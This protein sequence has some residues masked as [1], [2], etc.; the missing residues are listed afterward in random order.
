MD[1]CLVFYKKLWIFPGILK[2]SC[3]WLANRVAKCPKSFCLLSG[4]EGAAADEAESTTTRS[5][6][7]RRASKPKHVLCFAAGSSMHLVLSCGFALSRLRFPRLLGVL[8][9]CYAACD[10]IIIIL[11]ESVSLC[12]SMCACECCR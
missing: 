1:F 9:V 10:I 4:A 6:R 7:P 5:R 2:T 12:F 8:L 3:S 11:C